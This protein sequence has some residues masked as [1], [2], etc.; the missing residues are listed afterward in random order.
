MESTGGDRKS[1]PTSTSVSIVIPAYNEVDTIDP[2]IEE[3]IEA[4]ADGLADLYYLDEII[5]VDDGS[6]DGTWEALTSLAERVSELQAVRLRRNFGQSAALAAGIDRSVGDVVVTM[7][8]DQQ[9]PP[10]EIPNLLAKLHEGYECVSGWRRDRED[11]ASKTL[12]SRIQTSLAKLTGP[13]I[14]DFGCTLKAYDGQAIRS[15]DLF[16]EGHRYIPAQLYA[17][18]Y[19]VT[20]TE[21]SH[22]PRTRGETKYGTSRL[23]KG[24]LDLL[25][26]IFWIR[27]STRPIHLL[28]SLGA[29]SVLIGGLIGLHAIFIK[30]AYGVQLTTKLPRLVLV[31]ALVLFGVQLFM[32]GFLAEMVTK[33]H[34]RDQ[35]PYMIEEVLT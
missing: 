2:L 22:R 35:E 4:L 6:T 17:K 33:L 32:F 15:I 30:Y 21:V 16:G 3:T 29:V 24:S 14:N 9:N 1:N 26:N 7:D 12:P 19:R 11:P 18:G 28:G 5:V 31:I 23:I 20:E 25:F 34:Y 13:D 27:Y 8:A 10:S